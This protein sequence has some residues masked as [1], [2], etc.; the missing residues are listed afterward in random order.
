MEWIW[1]VAVVFLPI[2]YR[3][4]RRITLLEDEIRRLK[5]ELE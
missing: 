5:D 3:T 4:N 1:I 2:L